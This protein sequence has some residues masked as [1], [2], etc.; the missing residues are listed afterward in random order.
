MTELTIETLGSQGDGVGTLD[1]TEIFAAY[2]APGE[3]VSGELVGDRLEN[4]RILDPAPIRVKAPCRHFKTCGGCATQHIRGDFL[5]D[6]KRG[7]V[8]TALKRQGI[9]ATFRETVTS[10]PN[11]RRRAVFTGK[12]TKSGAMLGF[13][14]RSSDQLVAIETCTLLDPEILNGF[15]G[16]KSLVQLAAT[17]KGSVR[18]SVSTSL[19]GLDVDLTEAKPMD[20]GIMQDVVK[21]AHDSGFARVFWNGE[22][23]LERQPAQQEFGGAFVT[24]PNGAFLQAT[25]HGEAALWDSISE[26]VG[27]SKSVLDLFAGCGTF[28]LPLARTAEVVAIESSQ[29][30]LDAMDRG[31]RQAIGL[32]KLRTV[33]RDLFRNPLLSDEFKAYD[34]VVMDPPRAGAKEQTR[35]IADSGVTKIAF[36][37]CNPATFAR[38]ARTLLD[39]GFSLEWVQ[40]V[41][42][43]LWSGHCELVAHFSRR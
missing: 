5:A 32:K 13:H 38:D 37:S 11:S 18:L 20:T 40:V 12:R 26:I 36:V 34:A 21:I 28:S 33:Q 4:V 10:P 35:H 43:F 16:L 25:A 1:G 8:D 27:K 42:Q 41:D 39:G 15:N 6:W 30:M 29:P 14:A 3:T 22:I 31:W 24:P 9:E 7:I 23:V 2:T 19:G 17:R